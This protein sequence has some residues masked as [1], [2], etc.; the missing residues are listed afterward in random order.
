MP[1][2]VGSG[3]MTLGRGDR[4]RGGGRRQD[5][6]EGMN[7]EVAHKLSDQERAARVRH[8]WEEL[9]EILEVLVLAIAAIATAWS[10]YQAARGDGHQSVLY[11]ESS[12]DRFQADAASTLGGQRLAAD[13]SMF[14]AWLQARAD[15]NPQLQAALVRRFTPEYRGAFEAW[16][17][18]DP[19]TG[20][21]APPG[22][23]YLP[24]YR[25]PQLEEAERLNAHAAEA[26]A[27]GTADRETADR[28]VRVTVLFA[29]VLFLVAVGQRFR[30]R[31]VRIG[32]NALAVGLLVY[33]LVTV[34]TLPRL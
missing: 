11:A 17:K 7:V 22:P 2:A 15:S 30:V 4:E 8:R 12:R 13:A 28:Y 29:L 3:E 21:A 20:P 5:M 32:V 19:F 25:N 14:T 31:G 27:E 34:S 10:G 33:G 1:V 24:S 18:T 6:P 23:G 9:A 26:F 16:L